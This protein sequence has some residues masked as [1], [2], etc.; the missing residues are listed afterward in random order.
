MLLTASGGGGDC[1]EAAGA[2]LTSSAKELADKYEA[3]PKY[4]TVEVRVCAVCVCV[5][6]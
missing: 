2:G 1:G 3:N 6:V 4:S 5:C